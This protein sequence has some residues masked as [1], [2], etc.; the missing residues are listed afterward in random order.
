M[1]SKTSWI[2]KEIIIQSLRNVGWVGIVYFVGLLFALPVNIIGQLSRDPQF[3]PVAIYENLFKV[4]YPFQMGLMLFIPV[5]LS[6]FLFRYV[7]VKQ[8]GDFMH[9]LPIRRGTLFFHYTWLGFA[10][11][12]IPIVLNTIIL[13]TLYTV[14][15]LQQYIDIKDILLWCRDMSIMSL[16]L[17]TFATFVAMI[18]GL[19]AVQGALTYILLLLPAGIFMLISSSLNTLLFGF[20]EDYFFNVEIEKYSPLIKAVYLENAL[21][22]R[23]DIV[24]FAAITLIFYGLSY[25]LYDIRKAEFASQ[26]I[27]Y[28]F[29]R[30]VFQYGVA[31][32]FT[33]IGGSYFFALYQSQEWSWFGYFIGSFI[34]YY[35]GEMILQKNWRVFRHWKGYAGFAVSFALICFLIQTDL[36][37]YEEKVP[38]VADV[39]KVHISQSY[40]SLVDNPD[41][42]IKDPFMTDPKAIEAVINLHSEIIRKEELISSTDDRREQVFLYYKMKD[43]SK[44]VRNYSLHMDEVAAAYASLYEMKDFKENTEQIYSVNPK[45]IDRLTISPDMGMRESVEVTDPRQI[46]E[47]LKILKEEIYSTTVEDRDRVNLCSVNFEL[48]ED[49]W[50][51]VEINP[52]YTAFEAWLKDNGYFDDVTTKDSDIDWMYVIDQERDGKQVLNSMEAEQEVLDLI[53]DNKG[54]K[55][56]DPAEI[57]PLLKQLR[58]PQQANKYLVAIKYKMAR[59]IE[60]RSLKADDAPSGIVEQLNNL[61]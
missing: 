5:I 58:Y 35:I 52:D 11:L 10:L 17:F 4:Q 24:L 53:R 19:T 29:L 27:V 60:I 3:Y 12:I 50:F 28:P 21:F 20:P 31:L 8:S 36:F 45:K 14:T 55:L 23:T 25:K 40:Y 42:L 16:L 2:N 7:H 32:C 49:Q 26:T 54:I 59:Q 37:Q 15:D 38:D 34:G 57:G 41:N 56:D 43:G 33:L 22:T 39:E 13:I 46:N 18:T 48:S 51:Q 1:P 9:S 47:V 61:H 44:L 6:L 30:P